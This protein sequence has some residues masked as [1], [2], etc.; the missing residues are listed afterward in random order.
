ME[1][2][3]ASAYLNS[4][5][6][7]NLN[8]ATQDTAKAFGCEDVV[9]KYSAGSHDGKFGVFKV[10][11]KKGKVYG[12]AHWQNESNLTN[13]TNIKATVTIKK[14]D[15]STIKP[16]NEIEYVR[17]YNE[18]RCPSFFKREFHHKMFDQPA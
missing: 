1:K 2:V 11:N 4:Q 16:K 14:S 6:T 10:L 12:M 8:L 13:M 3:L 7:A 17:D 5:K 15:G 18:R 9:V